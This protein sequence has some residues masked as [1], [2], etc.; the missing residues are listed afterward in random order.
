MTVK[1]SKG[2]LVYLGHATSRWE[3]IDVFG[4]TYFLES[5]DEVDFKGN[6]RKFETQEEIILDFRNIYERLAE[7]EGYANS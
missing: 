5:L 6:P 2:D 1:Y 7:L 4:K 3:V